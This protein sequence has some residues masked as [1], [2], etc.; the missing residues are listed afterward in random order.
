MR[1][2]PQKNA[3]IALFLLEGDT[4]EVL[5]KAIFK[6]FIDPKI[7]RK[8]INLESGSG[9]NKSVAKN[10]EYYLKCNKNK[11]VY[12]YVLID[13][14]GPRSK[15][16]EFNGDA[17]LSALKCKR[18]IRV[19]R[20]E[21]IQMIESWFF[22]DLEGICKYIGL[23]CSK[24][25]QHKYANPEKLTRKDLADL[26]RKGTKRVYYKK[27]DESFLKI[28]KLDKIYKRCKELKEGILI[29]KSDFLI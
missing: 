5:Y 19:E 24:S 25:L 18:L 28:L 2:M 8:Y 11:T 1:T 22:Y 9:I 20:I 17:I 12:C 4:E 3:K 14:E 26:F 21:A 23:N 10:L 15:I 6:R 27:G 16:P 13:R 29:I 7:P